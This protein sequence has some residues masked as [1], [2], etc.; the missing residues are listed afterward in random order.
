MVQKIKILLVYP[1]IPATFWSFKYALG[2]ISKKSALPPLG[3]ITIAAML[4][5][6][7]E[8]KLVD[9]NVSKLKDKDILWADYVFISAM[10]IQKN[11]ALN[12]ID[13]CKSL[14][15]KL[16]AGGPMFTTDPEKFRDI[17]CFVLNEGEMTLPQF[18]EDVTNGCLKP[19]YS[20]N[21]L[22]NMNDSPPP[23]VDLLKLS[24]YAS[25]SIQ[26]SRGCP[27]NCE[28][29]DITLLYG[30]KVRTKT[31]D[32]LIY[33]LD[34]LYDAGWRDS[35][36]IVDDNFI[37]NK[38]KLTG[39]ILP[40][41]IEWM[42]EHKYPFRFN[43]Q[44]SIELADYENLMELMVK[45]G[46][47]A[48]FIG[49][50]TPNEGS[51]AECNKNQ[52]IKRDMIASVHKI[53]HY[54]LNVQGGFI[55]GFDNDPVSI[56]ESQ[57]KFIQES[58]IVTAM[59]G[60]LNALP[61][62]A[63]YQ[64]MVK[65]KRLVEDSS[66]DNTDASINFIPRMH[67]NTLIDGYKHTLTILYSSKKYFERMKTFLKLYRPAAPSGI[68]IRMIDIIALLKSFLYVGVFS[69]MRAD[70]WYLFYWTIFRR[71]GLL[72]IVITYSIYGYHFQKVVNKHMK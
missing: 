43:T 4:P 24:K 32:Q 62:T 51:L 52:N 25:M 42:K 35:V 56:F 31:K 58:G 65:E 9:T 36:F 19:L 29:C 2:F 16:V 38:G 23:R 54:G 13:R 63:L 10:N 46:F 7:W 34:C 12:I 22:A 26:Y 20:T 55:I 37:G 15:T 17:D 3:L 8:Q 41:M 30:H 14:K 33:E 70:F 69:K 40:A 21:G 5:R 44:T 67:L 59:V 53:Y 18:I 72:K 6:E 48:V 57:I 1:K 27:F 28:F 47:R 11:S 60:L 61:K 64:R 66:G 45:A 49:I 39:E 71:P 50:E 68:H